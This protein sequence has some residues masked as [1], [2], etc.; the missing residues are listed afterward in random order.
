[1]RITKSRLI[2]MIKEEARLLSEGIDAP[3]SEGLLDVLRGAF[4]KERPQGLDQSW[5]AAIEAAKR[6]EKGYAIAVRDARRFA[7]KAEAQAEE[8]AA[9]KAKIQ[10]LSPDEPPPSVSVDDETAYAELPHTGREY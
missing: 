9:L 6:L 7:K 4:A 2:E 3:V 5:D 1:M 10:E 8:I